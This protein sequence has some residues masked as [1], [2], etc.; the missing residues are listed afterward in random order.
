MLAE[1][2]FLQRF[3]V[4]TGGKI[5]SLILSTSREVYSLF[6]GAL[7]SSSESVRLPLSSRVI[8]PSYSFLPLFPSGEG[9]GNPLHHPCLENPMDGG[10]WQATVHG[11]T[12]SRTRLS[13]LTFFLS[14]LVCHFIIKNFLYILN[15]S[16]RQAILSFIISLM[17]KSPICQFL[18]LW[19]ML[20]VS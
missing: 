3:W 20:F 17:N 7:P 19:L 11:V 8:R 18:I 1:P 14:L 15:T 12:K 16:N 13:D 6:L 10:A 4:G 5:C 9:S 2:H